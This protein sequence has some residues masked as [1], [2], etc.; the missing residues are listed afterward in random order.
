MQYIVLYTIILHFIYIRNLFLLI[1]IR[2][3]SNNFVDSIIKKVFL[4][5]L[6]LNKVNILVLT[7]KM[8]YPA[9]DGGSIATLNL[10]LSLADCGAKVDLLA[11]NTNKH[12]SNINKIPHNIKNKISLSTIDIDTSLNYFKI[13]RNFLFSSIPYNA[14]RFISTEFNNKL[15]NLLQSNTYQ[16]VQLEGLYLCPYIDTIRQYST[17]HISLR[18]H[19]I[20]HEIWKR[21]LINETNIFKRLYISNLVRRIKKFKLKYLNKYDFLIP[22][23][24]R[25]SDTY[26]QLGN[27]LL[28]HVVPTG[29]EQSSS[30]FK[31]DI[32]KSKFPGFFYIGALD[33]LPNQEGLSWFVREVWSKFVAKYPEV[34]F[35]VAGRNASN[36]IVKLLNNHNVKY[37]GEVTNAVDFI[38]SGSVMIVPLFSGSGMRIK[39][40][41]GMAAGKTIISTTIGTEGINS[42][43]N[44]NILIADNAEDYYNQLVKIYHNQELH[45]RI[46][47]NARN[48]VLEN[49]NNK[50]I[51]QQLLNFYQTN[52]L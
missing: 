38:A 10:L 52:I 42:T 37:L 28:S 30:F 9:R 17:A 16:I 3:I 1:C 50:T 46:A 27:K 5:I 26:T 35:S 8:P 36:H 49:F 51:A 24:N 34:T 22:I 41:E 18:S 31:L 40:I 44:Y 29:L 21:G 12:Y 45:I 32:S 20:E 47:N 43:D 15:I 4:C 23:T 19:N 6:F 2:N 48:F 13:I 7:N 11:M 14:E 25:D 33:W 39:I